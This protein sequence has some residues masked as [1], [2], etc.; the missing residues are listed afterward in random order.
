MTLNIIR[1]MYRILLSLL[2]FIGFAFQTHAQNNDIIVTIDGQNVS[3]AEFEY[4]YHKNNTNLYN[5]SE[6]K[7]PKEY[8]ELF[9][10]FKLKVIEAENLKMD[11]NKVFIN[12]LAGYRKEIAA[13][14][15][16]DH[17]YDDQL[18]HE[19]Y[20]RMT[21][22]VN[23][24]HI[25]LLVDKNAP[26]AKEKQVLDKIKDIREEINNGKDFA[27]A[28]MEYSEDPSAKKNKGNLGYFSAFTMVAPFEDAAFT[29]P[30]GEISEP[31]R[32]SF[33]YHLIKVH[34]LR[35]NKGEIQ[36][37]HIM[38]NVP[39]AATPEVRQKAKEEIEAIYQLLINGADFAELAKKESQDKR[40]AVKGGEMPW[41][42][43]GRI[44]PEF[45][46]AAFALQ[47]NGDISKPVETPFGYHIIKKLNQRP[48]PPFEKVKNEIESKIRKDQARRTSSKKV[49]INKLKTE[50]NFQENEE[51]KRAMQGMN[52][53]NKQTIPE[54]DLFSIDNKTYKTTDLISYVQENRIK[55]GLYLSVYDQWIDDEITKL[56]DSKLEEKYPEFRY[57]LNEYH[58]GIL[59]FNIS[60]EKIWNF[61]SAD[62]VGLENFYEKNK[63]K[64]HW[65]E[66]FKGSIIT[67]KSAEVRE[68]A[69]DLLGAGMTNDEVTAHLNTDEEIISFE[70]GAWEEG[71]NHIVDYYVWNGR[72]PENFD[73]ATTFVR[74]NKVGPEQK[75]LN[76]ARGLYISEYQSYLE[77][78]WIK[79]LRSKYKIK[80]NKKV[81]KTIEGV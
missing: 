75:L 64:H 7:S 45:S 14:Y 32:T 36:V 26:A 44:V 43:A 1:K 2:V 50:Y 23:A 67:C 74:G 49:F 48:V 47:N 4:I 41:F 60:Q 59:L 42:S 80:I 20:R 35:E 34:D 17:D 24:S 30:V 52:I 71:R 51:G 39:Q 63:S 31:I 15:L 77:K 19:L 54:L 21:H 58:D 46:N 33:G 55:S 6:I 73:S 40:S 38:K 61:A 53:Q 28:A 29:T 27:E 65:G 57:L 8:L 9:I 81:L 18:V 79:Q 68:K 13:P 11:T 69:E 66:R 72:E 16:T 76:E 37:A 70:T 62:T 12:E 78:N 22:E 25:L 10:D 3:K 5:D 56:E